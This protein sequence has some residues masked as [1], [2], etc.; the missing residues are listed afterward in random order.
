MVRFF[1]RRTRDEDDDAFADADG[2]DPNGGTIGFDSTSATSPIVP[3]RSVAGRALLF[4]IA[5]MT[6]LSCLTVGAVTL[7]NAAAGDWQSDISRE[8]TIQI[9]PVDGQ[10]MLAKLDAAVRIAEAQPG[11]DS[12]SAL[13]VADTNA[14]LEPWL[15]SDLDLGELPVP[16]LVV[17]TLGDPALLDIAAFRAAL[18]AEVSTATVDDHSTWSGQLASVA[19]T[20][21]IGGFSI[22]ALMLIA[23]A[24]SIVFATR[25]AIASNVQVIEVLHFVGAENGFVA[26]EF[27]KHFLL[28]GLIGGLLGGGSAVAVF[29]AIELVAGGA[30]GTAS[31][32]QAQALLGP[33]TIGLP[34]Y[35]AALAIVFAVAILTALTSR[36]AV[37]RHLTNLD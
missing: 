15:G 5:I 27:Q 26:R 6:F 28:K 35:I 22:V 14:L 23:L 9:R 16:R 10:D 3:A 31:V 18:T 32:A 8:I 11:V 19:R 17:V 33:L 1:R 30:R 24:L 29:V 4:V 36:I 37:H 20:V 34:G 21:V 25:A 13:S 2:R 7:V 12:A